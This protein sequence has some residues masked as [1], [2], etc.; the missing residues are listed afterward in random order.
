M[1]IGSAR[2]D[3]SCPGEISKSFRLAGWMTEE[4][5]RQ[6]MAVDTL[7]LSLTTSEYGRNIHPCKGCVSTAMPLCHWPCSCYPNHSLGQT[8][9]W[10]NE[11]YPRWVAAHAIV[12]VSPVYWYQSPSPLKLMIDRLVCADGGNPDPSSTHGKK[13]EE[14]KALEMAGWDYPKH[15]DGRAY[16][17]MVHGDV[18]GIEGS[19][20][21]LSDWLDWMGLID[22]GQ[23]ALLDRFIGYYEPY[24][25]SHETLDRD[26]AVQQEARNVALAVAHAVKE[27]RTGTLAAVQPQVR[28]PR[29]K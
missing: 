23:P 2:N 4:L 3:G 18:A 22:S 29:P 15:M 26:L 28:R 25:T 16:G 1:I 5:E 8:G 21:S 19:R 9:D 11:I 6:G 12:I 13:A 17:L 24:A 10:M 27:L 14:A 7:D 20:R